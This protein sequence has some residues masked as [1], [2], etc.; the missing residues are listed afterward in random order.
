[1]FTIDGKGSYKCTRAENN[2]VIVC[3]IWDEAFFS[4]VIDG[5]GC[6]KNEI[7]SHI[8]FEL[9]RF[10]NADSQPVSTS[11]FVRFFIDMVGEFK[12]GGSACCAFVYQ[13]GE[14]MVYASVGDCRIY[15]VADRER[16]V[17]DTVAQDLIDRGRLKANLYNSHP[18]RRYVTKTIPRVSIE[19]RQRKPLMNG[20]V[21]VLCSDGA[22][23]ILSDDDFYAN[24]AGELVASLERVIGDRGVDNASFVVITKS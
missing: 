23:S 14:E 10:F 21:V 5:V 24:S 13:C 15:W 16:T 2:D 18:Y 12:G 1:M 11:Y 20:D 3:F 9:N 19:V 7:C 17:D 22:W 6:G 8:E 4:C